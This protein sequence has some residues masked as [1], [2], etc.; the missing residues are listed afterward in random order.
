MTQNRPMDFVDWE[1][2]LERHEPRRLLSFESEDE[3]H[4]AYEA[5]C[6]RVRQEEY[7]D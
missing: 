1:A 2:W 6:D 3:K 7:D 5:Y 4:E